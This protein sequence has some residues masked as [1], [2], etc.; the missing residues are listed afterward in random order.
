MEKNSLNDYPGKVSCVLFT[1][2][3]NYYCPYCHNPRAAKNSFDTLISIEEALD[4]I[5]PRTNLYDGIVIS[6]GEPTIN[7]SLPTVCRSIKE[8]GYPIKLDTNGSRPFMIKEL[9]DHKLIDYVAMDIK[10]SPSIAAYIGGSL[11]EQLTDEANATMPIR[12]SI[13]IIMDNAPDYEFRTTCVRPYVSQ[14]I[15]QEICTFISG[16]KKYVLQ[17]FNETAKDILNK[18]ALPENYAISKEEIVKFSK[19]IKY[20]LTS[21]VLP[22]IQ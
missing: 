8:L 22:D 5:R 20:N 13:E 15:I 1:A 11:Y 10:S 17:A 4:F 2:G 3:C 7:P 19:N 9:L 21:M 14:E 16:A 12:R 18:E 6:G